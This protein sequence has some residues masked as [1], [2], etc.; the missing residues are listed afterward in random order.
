M[1]RAQIAR[2]GGVGIETL[3]QLGEADPEIDVPRLAEPTFAKLR[4]QAAL[5]LEFRRTGSH[6]AKTLEPEPERGFALLPKP[7]PGDLFFDIEGDPFWEP[8]RGLEYLLGVSEIVDGEPVFRAFWAHDR[9][10]ERAAFEQFVDFVHERLRVRPDLHVYHYAPYEP[11]ALKRLAAAFATHEEEVDELLRREVLVD[12]YAVVRQGLRI[13]HP[14]YSLKNVEQFFMARQAALKAGDDSIVLYERWR[15]ERDPRILD[16]IS[17][18]NEEDCLSTYLLREWLLERKAEAEA[19]WGTEIA[20]RDPPELREPNEEAIEEREERERLRDELLERGEV[21][22]A[23]LLDYH[24]REAKPVWWS[25]FDRLEQTREE[26]VEDAE[27]IGA[28]ELVE[29]RGDG[30]HLFRFPLQQ[31]KLDAGD[32]VIDPLTGKGAG[33]I[34]ALDDVAGTLELARGKQIDERPL[35]QALIPGGP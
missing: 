20:W 5:Q 35:P 2:L 9:D 28:L 34:R 22:A 3:E 16:A 29:S 32:A 24:R 4:E 30:V 27:A 33:H 8:G 19:E 17:D 6:R 7:S 11:S 23:R 12:L 1:R 31:H 14:R 21:L 25:F 13:S 18:Y 10:G 26:L 15:E